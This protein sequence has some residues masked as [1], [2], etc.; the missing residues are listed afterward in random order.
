MLYVDLPSINPKAPVRP[1]LGQEGMPIYLGAAR[2]A[3]LSGAA[4]LPMVPIW[5]EDDGLVIEWGQPI[6]PATSGLREDDIAVHNQVLDQI[7]KAIGRNLLNYTF[8]HFLF[9][10]TQ[11]SWNP[12]T[13]AWER[14]S[15]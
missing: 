11:R 5:T 10:P 2:I 1:F 7:E 3:R 14:L 15:P 13:D 12:A 8:K 4:I 9:E 6:E